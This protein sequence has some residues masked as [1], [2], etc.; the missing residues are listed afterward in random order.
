MYGRVHKTALLNDCIPCLVHLKQSYDSS[1]TNRC[2]T[3]AECSVREINYW[4]YS[5]CHTIG[6]QFT[7]NCALFKAL[8]I[9][10]NLIRYKFVVIWI[11]CIWLVAVCTHVI[12]FYPITLRVLGL[13]CLNR[14]HV[15]G[16]MRVESVQIAFC[17]SLVFRVVV[18]LW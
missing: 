6:R 3:V 1:Q 7:F 10:H 5:N 13:S 16:S 18:L 4:I 11:Q 2:I 17:Q 12:G 8:T 9:I 14:W 15:T